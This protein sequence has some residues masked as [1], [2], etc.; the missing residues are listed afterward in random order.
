MKS[1]VSLQTGIAGRPRWFNALY[2]TLPGGEIQQLV[3]WLREGVNEAAFAQSWREV[4][5]RRGFCDAQ[6]WEVP[7]Q[8][9]TAVEI[10]F[11]KKD[12]RGLSV[13]EQN[14]R[15][16]QYLRSDRHH[17]FNLD[18]SPRMRVALFQF[19]EM[20]FKFVWTFPQP[21]LDDQDVISILEEVLAS[22]EAIV[23]PSGEG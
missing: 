2:C 1:D 13:D 10:C 8:P 15:F 20:D 6:P 4:M 12:I 16:D 11:V 5:A 21:L 7:L 3:C 23:D 19:T 9:G 18:A 17:A 14:E 22:H